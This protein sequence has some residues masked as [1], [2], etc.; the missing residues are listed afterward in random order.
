[1]VT[2][3]LKPP[4]F[5]ILKYSKKPKNNSVLSVASAER[6]EFN[7]QGATVVQVVTGIQTHVYLI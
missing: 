6:T 5:E 1:M 4:K 3:S 7:E 2:F